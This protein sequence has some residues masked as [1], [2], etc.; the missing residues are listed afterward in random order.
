MS[1]ARRESKRVW[2]AQ[3]YDRTSGDYLGEEIFA[4]PNLN[5]DACDEIEIARWRYALSRHG[6]LREC[7][8]VTPIA[9]Q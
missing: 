8:E 4:V 9:S 1:G 2:R 6:R 3:I 7:L 5:Y